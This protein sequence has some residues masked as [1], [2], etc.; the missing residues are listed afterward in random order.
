V[1][2]PR[3]T[4]KGGGLFSIFAATATSATNRIFFSEPYL[5]VTVEE[6]DAPRAGSYYEHDERLCRVVRVERPKDW[7]DTQVTIV[8]TNGPIEHAREN[9]WEKSQFMTL[10]NKLPKVRFLQK[11]VDWLEDEMEDRS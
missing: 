7:F 10:L 1:I 11:T 2:K 6:E 4:G 8:L 5:R 9:P 3:A